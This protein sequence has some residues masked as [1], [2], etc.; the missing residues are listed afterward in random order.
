[1]FMPELHLIR[2]ILHISAN[3]VG[4]KTPVFHHRVKV[5]MKWNFCPLFLCQKSLCCIDS[6][7]SKF[8]LWSNVQ[9]NFS[10]PPKLTK[11]AIVVFRG[12][13]LL[14]S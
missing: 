3:Q 12:L 13:E 2:N 7:I 6:Q 9:N 10:I 11:N 8:K 1:M 5:P 14:T 4:E